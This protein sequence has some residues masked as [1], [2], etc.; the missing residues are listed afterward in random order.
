[1][2]LASALISFGDVFRVHHVGGFSIQ[3]A[4]MQVDDI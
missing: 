4:M 2:P 1:M 3:A